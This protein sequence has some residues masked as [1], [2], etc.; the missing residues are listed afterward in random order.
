MSSSESSDYERTY[1][2]REDDVKVETTFINNKFKQR[3][4]PGIY[5]QAK[6]QNM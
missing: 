4:H 5:C 2:M 6:Y 1:A 3:K